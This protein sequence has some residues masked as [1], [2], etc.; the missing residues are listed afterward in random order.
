[1]RPLFPTLVILAALG[2]V[3]ALASG[4]EE[5][6]PDAAQAQPAQAQPV[7]AHGHA[8][9]QSPSQEPTTGSTDPNPPR[10]SARAQSC[11]SGG[12]MREVVSER[13]VMEPIAAIRAARE[14]LPR[15]EIVRVNLCHREGEPLFYLITA[16][17]RD[18][19]FVHVTVDSQTGAV[20]ALQ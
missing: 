10:P 12:D 11:L 16:L 17:R 20:S 18:G 19:Q 8:P 14:A 15:A 2:P 9:S 1:M 3:V 6:R 7:Q 5:Q 4:A 13:K